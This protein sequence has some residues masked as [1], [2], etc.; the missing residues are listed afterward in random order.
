MGDHGGGN[1]LPAR[2]GKGRDSEQVGVA[3]AVAE[4]EP[5][6]AREPTAV[7][8]AR[9]GGTRPGPPLPRRT[10]ADDVAPVGARTGGGRQLGAQQRR[11]PG[12]RA[13]QRG[14]RPG[15]GR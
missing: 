14:L 6:I 3:A 15:D 11:A 13:E 2:G 7:W 9:A 12:L 4:P 5:G 8:A 10:V 1:A